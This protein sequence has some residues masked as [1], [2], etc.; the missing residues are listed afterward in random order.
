MPRASCVV[1]VL[2]QT[3]L[4]LESAALYVLPGALGDGVEGEGVHPPSRSQLERAWRATLFRREHQRARGRWAQTDW[5]RGA[6]SMEAIRLT[7]DLIDLDARRKAVLWGD[8]AG[9]RAL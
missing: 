1:D 7:W 2:P 8:L 6:A 5:E 9:A 3:A 4:G